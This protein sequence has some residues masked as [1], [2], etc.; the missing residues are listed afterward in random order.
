MKRHILLMTTAFFLAVS[1]TVALS[2]Y[3]TV[4]YEKVFK[5]KSLSGIVGAGCAT[6]LKG[7]SPDEMSRVVKGVLVEEMT[8]NWGAVLSSTRT[9]ENGHFSIHA[10]AGKNLHYLRLSASGFNPTFVKVKVSTWA[11]K[12]EL[13]F[14]LQIAS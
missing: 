6:C 3:E 13:T 12:R 1:P 2:Q 11:R 10:S 8:S 14:L 4:Q 7:A 9:D 5:S